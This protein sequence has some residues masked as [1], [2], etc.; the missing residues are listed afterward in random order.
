MRDSPHLTEEIIQRP[1]Q[2]VTLHVPHQVFQIP[3]LLPK[4]LHSPLIKGSSLVSYHKHIVQFPPEP[5]LCYPTP[6]PTDYPSLSPFSAEALTFSQFPQLNEFS[7]QVSQRF[8]ESLNCL[9]SSSHCSL[10]P[11]FKLL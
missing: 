4:L 5:P 10:N 11:D 3:S 8:S 2:G 6:A 1:E 7:Y 9:T